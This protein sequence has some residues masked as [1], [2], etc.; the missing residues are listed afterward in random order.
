VEEAW[1]LFSNWCARGRGMWQKTGYLL[2]L[3]A[4][5]ARMI[6]AHLEG[7]QAHWTKG[8]KTASVERLNGL[9]SALKRNA[10]GC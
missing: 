2:E 10:R 8:L 7:I 4:R 9:L 3:M 1:M 6:E 5:G